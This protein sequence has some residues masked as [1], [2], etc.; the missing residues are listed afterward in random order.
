MVTLS[1]PFE[2]SLQEASMALSKESPQASLFISSRALPN[3]GRLRRL[4]R[5][6]RLTERIIVKVEIS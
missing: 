6:K 2:E 3:F 4:K 1:K 5:V